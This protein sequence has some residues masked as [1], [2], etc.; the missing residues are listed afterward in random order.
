MI[1][2][3]QA[4]NPIVNSFPPPVGYPVKKTE[5]VGYLGLFLQSMTAPDNSTTTSFEERSI[6]PINGSWSGLLNEIARFLLVEKVGMSENDP[7]SLNMSLIL[8]QVLLT[9]GMVNLNANLPLHLDDP[10]FIRHLTAN[11]LNLFFNHDFKSLDFDADPASEKGTALRLELNKI[12]DVFMVSAGLDLEHVKDKPGLVHLLYPNTFAKFGLGFLSY[13]TGLPSI[14]RSS[15]E[16]LFV[17]SAI[18]ILRPQRKLE[19][20]SQATILSYNEG[21]LELIDFFVKTKIVKKLRTGDLAF[22]YSFLR[23]KKNATFLTSMINKVVIEPGSDN[24]ECPDSRVINQAWE[25]IENQLKMT[26]QAIFAVLLT[27][28]PGQTPS[29]RRDALVIGILDRLSEHTEGLNKR[30]LHIKKMKSSELEQALTTVKGAYEERAKEMLSRR[31]VK[32]EDE[33]TSF[34]NEA[35]TAKVS[36]NETLS[37]KELLARLKAWEVEKKNN[38]IWSVAFSERA[39]TLLKQEG[40]SWKSQARALLKKIEY[41]QASQSVL[42]NELNPQKFAEFIPKLFKVGDLFQGLYEFIGES[43]LEFHEQQQFLEQAGKHALDTINSSTIAALPKFVEELMTGLILTLEE[44]AE[45][46]EIHVGY[47]KFLDETLSSLLKVPEEIV[48]D[49]LEENAEDSLEDSVAYDESQFHGQGKIF[50]KDEVKALA[51]NILMV[52][53]KKAI[54]RNLQV[55]CPEGATLPWE[56]NELA[57]IALEEAFANLVNHFVKNALEGFNTISESCNVIKEKPNT[58]KLKEVQRLVTLLGIKKIKV[59]NM[60]EELVA[61]Y[62]QL[63]VYSLSRKLMS[64]IM[65]EELFNSLLPP[66]FKKSGLW[67]WVVEGMVAPYLEGISKK[68]ESFKRAEFQED[69]LEAKLLKLQGDSLQLQ[70]LLKPLTAKACEL[71]S[72]VKFAKLFNSTKKDSKLT[73][74]NFE[75]LDDLFGNALQQ[76]GQITRLIELILPRC[77]ESILAFHLNSEKEKSSQERATELLWIILEITHDCYTKMS[78]L[79]Q[80]ELSAAAFNDAFNQ[81]THAALKKLMDRLIPESLWDV[82]VPK[83]FNQLIDRNQIGQLLLSYIKEGYAHSTHMKKMVSEGKIH[84]QNAEAEKD[85]EANVGLHPYIEK[86]VI[87]G[88]E[89]AA[90]KHEEEEEGIQWMRGV[91]R[92]LLRKE[93]DTQRKLLTEIAIN[94]VYALFSKLLAG[95]LSSLSRVPGIV[96]EDEKSGSDLS[97]IGKIAKL[98][99]EIRSDYYKLNALH[100]E[101]KCSAL[102]QI[103]VEN[104]RKYLSLGKEGLKEHEMIEKISDKFEKK[105]KII[106]LNISIRNTK[107][108][109]AREISVDVVRFVYWQVSYQVLNEL[110]SDQEWKEITP[111]LMHPIMTKEVLAEFA[112]PYVH[113]ARQ[114]QEPLQTKA[115]AGKKLIEE[116]CTE[117]PTENLKKMIDAKIIKNVDAFL[118]E[119]ANDSEPFDPT[120]P[121][122]LDKLLKD[123]LKTHSNKNILRVR[124]E[125]VERVCY[126]LLNELLRPV[127]KEDEEAVK[128]SLTK[129]SASNILL[130][131]NQIVAVYGSSKKNPVEIAGKI[132]NAFISEAT[133]NEIFTGKFYDLIT[134]QALIVPL[135]KK[136]K[137][138]CGAIDVLDRKQTEAMAQIQELDQQALDDESYGGGM[139]K[140][141]QL[142]CGTLDQVIESLV[143]KK[144]KLFEGQPLFIDVLA[145]GA[146]S[147]PQ[148]VKVIKNFFHS[149]VWILLAKVFQVE[150]GQIPEEQLLKILSSLINTY[151]A[152]DPKATATAWLQELLPEELRKE[153]VPPFLHNVLTHTFIAEKVLLGAFPEVSAVVRAFGKVPPKKE[154]KAIHRLQG[155]VKR[156]IAKYSD[157]DYS[158]EGV[159]GLGGF[160]KPLETI[161]AAAATG[162]LKEGEKFDVASETLGKF[163]DG[164]VVQALTLPKVKKLLHQQFL[165]EALIDALPLFNALNLEAKPPND[166]KKVEKDFQQQSAKVICEILFP[167]GAVDVPLPTAV[168]SRVLNQIQDA[169]A[170]M[171]RHF[172]NRD[173]RLLT[174]IKF[175][176]VSPASTKEFIAMEEQLKK[177]GHLKGKEQIAER[178]F[179]SGLTAFIMQ[180]IDQKMARGWPKLFRWLAIQFVKG[181]V[182]A[183][184]KIAIHHQVWTFVSDAKN[185]LKFRAFMWKFLNFAKTYEPKVKKAAEL[186]GHLKKEL[187]ESFKNLGLFSGIRWGVSSVAASFIQEQNLVTLIDE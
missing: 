78:E 133:W 58:E 118:N 61:K 165:A 10:A 2:P 179:K 151:N 102:P 69:S 21:L 28:K 99:P 26:I 115:E 169:A 142:L 83:E 77:L 109:E 132:V 65:P 117:D 123:L 34:I 181:V 56:K 106:V 47:G 110:I 49:A 20:K 62:R 172:I 59:K 183:A 84:L 92:H 121:A 153:I 148:I 126:L 30:A 93:K 85:A 159:S 108:E 134:H 13:A 48:L 86:K 150:E 164:A 113:A 127:E 182:K 140:A 74:V 105:E 82:Y 55:D 154:K 22:E 145:K 60:D 44:K 53:I 168:Q 50:A 4:K 152:A 57:G 112:V 107:T 72:G 63:L 54:D 136:I 135:E 131:L 166:L 187:S 175:F 68:V 143:L 37:H 103:T 88:L 129:V 66:M 138:I 146:F 124:N 76:G 156:T 170:S 149:L 12:F 177:R 43:A 186:N 98:I 155:L 5:N 89:K 52:V 128:P 75:I 184:L 42:K 144:E 139:E 176:G 125:L 15:F 141:I 41:V 25:A 80:Q 174:L 87:S 94:G 31:G 46:N 101:Q 104:S 180:K 45:K 79:Q 185:D 23:S 1:P 24:L 167:N 97:L 147:D 162:G 111:T 171:M 90:E 158:K 18:A 11:L 27:A 32:W 33:V 96:N 160:V 6:H 114:I 119:I 29:Q 120:L 19:I 122:V 178:L 157:P 73:K 51:K 116:L 9:I 3:T 70:P 161:L 8:K 130:K 64:H 91:I 100:A 7:L 39:H 16:S 81:E 40:R 36:V 14:N 35:W 71:I 67:T 163:I 38:P 173:Q 95:G 137:E 17:E